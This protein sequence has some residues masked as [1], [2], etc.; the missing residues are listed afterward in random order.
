[1]GHSVRCYIVSDLICGRPNEWAELYNPAR[2]TFRS[3]GEFLKENLNV[4]A[5]YKDY[6]APGRFKSEDEIPPGFGAVLGAGLKKQA[7]Y[8][9]PDGNLVRLSAICPHLKC[10]V[11][12]NPGESTWDCPCHGS[13]STAEGEVVTGPATAALE[14]VK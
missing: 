13:R 11:H 8:R 6:L 2:T 1:M 14:P 3:G 5:T 12:W 7:I 9:S 10:V 4:A